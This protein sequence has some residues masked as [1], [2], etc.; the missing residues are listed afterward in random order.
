[1]D[2]EIKKQI[3]D[4][5]EEILSN[6][7][8]SKKAIKPWDLLDSDMK[9][10][11][12]ESDSANQ[13]K[14]TEIT[15]TGLA[16]F[17]SKVILLVTENSKLFIKTFVTLAVLG[18]FSMSLVPS[19]YYSTLHLFAPEFADTIGTRLSLFT[20]RIEYASFPVDY[21]TP[22]SILS[23]R[24]REDVAKEWVLNKIKSNPEL[25]KKMDGLKDSSV[26]VETNYVPI[27]QLLQIDGYANSPE[28]AVEISK[29]YHQ[30]L[31]ESISKI[32]AAQSEKV[33]MWFDLTNKS[34]DEQMDAVSRQIKDIMPQTTGKVSTL[35]LRDLLGDSYSDS[36]IKKTDLIKTISELKKLSNLTS[37]EN[38]TESIDPEVQTQLRIYN[39]LLQRQ[40]FVDGIQLRDAARMLKQT[41][42][43]KMQESEYSLSSLQANQVSTI[44]KI[45]E[46]GS[47]DGDIRMI[48][49]QEGDLR[50]QLATLRMQKVE[51]TKFKSQ[52]EMENGIRTATY[53]TIKEPLPNDSSIRPLPAIKYSIALV[54]AAIFSLLVIYCYS[55]YSNRKINYKF[56]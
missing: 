50:L 34:V 7:T 26:S 31:L 38:V 3:R 8:K 16:A 5:D 30:Y 25:L 1:M 18:L 29:L 54:L 17:V 56:E 36:E 45:A 11:N 21:R 41:I 46:V 27:Q 23:R 53:K 40:Q 43:L 12:F 15:E 19:S 14:K 24:L 33:R 4:F 9:D 28:L 42:Q 52:V 13:E 35:K 6:K 44:R 22:V 10:Y 51:L 39:Q 47:R 48:N 37:Y 32:E 20:Q 2:N 55:L 49:D